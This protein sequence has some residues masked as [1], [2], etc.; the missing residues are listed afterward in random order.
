MFLAVAKIG[1]EEIARYITEEHPVVEAVEKRDIGKFHPR[2]I[3]KSYTIL[4]EEIKPLNSYS[5]ILFSN[6]EPGIPLDELNSGYMVTMPG[7]DKALTIVNNTVGDV[8]MRRL[9]IAENPDAAIRKFRHWQRE[10]LPER[11]LTEL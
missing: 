4:I 2:L 11:Y 7:E 5:V 9:V 1:G 3:D 8:L 10:G 6:A